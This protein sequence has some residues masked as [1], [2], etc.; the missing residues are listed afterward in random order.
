MRSWHWTNDCCRGHT[1][2]GFEFK[3]FLGCP[4]GPFWGHHQLYSWRLD[5]TAGTE[6]SRTFG[7]FNAHIIRFARCYCHALRTS[8]GTEA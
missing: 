4:F 3:F 1:N 5:Y 8:G 7:L 2:G 6:V